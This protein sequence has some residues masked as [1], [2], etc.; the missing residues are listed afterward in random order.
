MAGRLING[1]HCK[2][3]GRLWFQFAAEFMRRDHVVDL[4]YVVIVGVRTDNAELDD[5]TGDGECTGI[6]RWR[7]LQ[8][9]QCAFDPDGI[10][11]TRCTRFTYVKPTTYVSFNRYF[12][13]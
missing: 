1:S 2:L 4:L 12:R 8:S 10:W 9:H 5:V 13:V 6:V 7:P 3:V 11:T